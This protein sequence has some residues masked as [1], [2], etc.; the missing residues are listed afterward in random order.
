MTRINQNLNH[1][2]ST[3]LDIILN[4]MD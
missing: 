4:K 2:Y 3:K 1:I